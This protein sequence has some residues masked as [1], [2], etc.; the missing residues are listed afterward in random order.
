VPL[1]GH[2]P[3]PS[4]SNHLAVPLAF[5][6][7]GTASPT[8]LAPK[9]SPLADVF[10]R[11]VVTVP[12]AGGR[13]QERVLL[14]DSCFP[15]GTFA[16]VQDLF[17]DLADTPRKIALERLVHELST[18]P[19]SAALFLP[20]ST[21]KVQRTEATHR[22]VVPAPK[23]REALGVIL[24][25]MALAAHHEIWPAKG[26]HSPWRCCERPRRSPGCA[27]GFRASRKV[28]SRGPAS[29]ALE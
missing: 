2:P 5:T 17:G 19:C 18:I 3:G 11:S 29:I 20:A 25:P 23:A 6:H 12:F 26:A 15:N 14:T 27:E 8:L 16:G 21:R 22:Y 24:R 7:H 28:G 13:S 10:L 4:R 1:W 9:T